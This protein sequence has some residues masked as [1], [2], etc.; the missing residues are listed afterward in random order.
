MRRIAR[1]FG[2]D[3][4]LVED[5]RGNTQRACFVLHPLANDHGPIT[6]GAFLTSLG[7]HERAAG[8]K[9]RASDEQID[10]IDAALIRLTGRDQQHMGELFKVMAVSTP[11]LPPLPAFPDDFI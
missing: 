11:G 8:L 4:K 5:D 9:R 2:T 3:I 10:E 6:Q 1:H 7:I